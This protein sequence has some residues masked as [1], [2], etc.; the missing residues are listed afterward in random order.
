QVA[1]TTF[2]R[3]EYGTV[4]ATVTRVSDFPA[5]Q[6]GMMRTLANLNLVQALSGGAAPYEVYASLE[7]DPDTPTGYAWSSS[8]GPDARLQSGT[9]VTATIAVD[10]QRPLA[11]V[12]PAL[13]KW[14][15]IGV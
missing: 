15:G 12:I 9:V 10:E 11:L 8:R 13:R 5:T 3:E 1:P 6:E 2:K 7:L 4:R 14:T